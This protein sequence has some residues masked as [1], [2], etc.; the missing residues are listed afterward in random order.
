MF[1]SIMDPVSEVSLAAFTSEAAIGYAA[2][3]RR[4]LWSTILLVAKF[5]ANDQAS[6]DATDFPKEICRQS[7]S[8]ITL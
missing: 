5:Q 7:M 8:P 1:G 2:S 3:F 6:H 4:A